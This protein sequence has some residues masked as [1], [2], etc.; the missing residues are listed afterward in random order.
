MFAYVGQCFAAIS[1]GLADG[2]QRT[3]GTY[4]GSTA[5]IGLYNAASDAVRILLYGKR[6]S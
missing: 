1:R 6:T 5:Q 4:A 3:P 2:L